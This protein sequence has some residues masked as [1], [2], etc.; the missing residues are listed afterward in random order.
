MV[1]GTSKSIWDDDRRSVSDWLGRGLIAR[2]DGVGYAA[3]AGESRQRILA[4]P[5]M[6]YSQFRGRL[7]MWV[8]DWKCKQVLVPRVW[9]LAG[10]RSLT[11]PR[12]IKLPVNCN[13]GGGSV[14]YRL[15]PTREGGSAGA[16]IFQR[17][18]LLGGSGP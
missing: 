15:A 6:A 17:L 10:L 4:M 14:F 13:R 2:Y 5:S 3:D 18:N 9:A 11:R 1:V 12:P 16:Q 8:G 7:R